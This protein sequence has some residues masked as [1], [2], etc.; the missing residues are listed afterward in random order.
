MS[1]LPKNYKAPAGS[2]SFMKLEEGEN[3]FRVLSEATI[4]WEGWIDGK[5]FRRKGIE[6]NITPDE[7]EINKMSKKPAIN[8]FW[9]FLVYDYADGQVKILEITQKTI[10][11]ALEGLSNDSDWGDPVKYDISI[12]RVDGNKVSYN[13]KPFPPKP[14]SAEIKKA[15]AASEL[16][17]DEAMFKDADEDDGFGDFKGHIKKGKK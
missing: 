10:M 3:R 1:F 17:I 9:A 14:I 4:G 11:R 5:P 16:D 7:V 8:H 15:Q 12:E 2:S 6:Q 13:V